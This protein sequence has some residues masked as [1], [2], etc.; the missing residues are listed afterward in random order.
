MAKRKLLKVKEWI[1]LGE[2]SEPCKTNRDI[3]DQAADLLDGACSHDILGQVLF[4]AT[5]GK[6]Y[7]VTVEALIGEAEKGFVKDA[8]AEKA[9]EEG[10]ICDECGA[11]IPDLNGG[12]MVNKHH[13]KSCSLHKD[14]VA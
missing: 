5:N 2:L 3:L 9:E 8:L 10:R 4:K 12:S 6:Y 13:E 7:T 14:N 11:E 1:S